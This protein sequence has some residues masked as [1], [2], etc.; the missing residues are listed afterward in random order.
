[1]TAAPRTQAGHTAPVR[2]SARAYTAKL[3]PVGSVVGVLV[4]WTLLAAALAGRELVPYPW[5]VLAQMAKDFP[6]LA[7]GNTASTVSIAARGFLVGAVAMIPLAVIAVL[8]PVTEALIVQIALVIHSVPF[9]AIAP[10][11]VIVLP[12]DGPKIAIAAL[13][14]YFPLLMSA[15]LGLRAADPLM[16]D[17]VDASGGS[18]W[19]LMRRVRLP[20]ALPALFAGLQIAV[21]GALLGALIAEFFGTNSGL[22]ALLVQSQSALNTERAWAVALYISALAALGYGIVALTAR[23]LMPWQSK[24]ASVSVALGGVEPSGGPWSKVMGTLLSVALLLAG[25]QSLLSALRLDAFFVKGPADV[26]RFLIDNPSATEGAMPSLTG[27]VGG[28]GF[29]AEFWPGLGQTVVDA[30]AGFLAGTVGAV[31]VAV[32]LSAAPGLE[33]VLMPLAIALKSV[34]LVAMTPLLVLVLGRNLVAVTVMVAIITFFPTL[35]NVLVAL[36]GAPVGACDVVRAAGGTAVQVGRY[37]RL[38]YAVPALLAS[39]RIAVPAAVSGAT[40]AEWLATD[41][42]LGHV[43]TD[44]A[45][46]SDFDTLWSAGFLLVIV[47]L[48]LYALVALVDRRVSARLGIAAR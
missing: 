36:K 25:W 46:G 40:L 35:V 28:G 32:L 38:V 18:R 41:Q 27:N 1:M 15:L 24:D 21:P 7:G 30:G 45:Q 4:A 16:A 20:A 31:A 2:P 8:A 44:A 33:R 12:G 13:Q 47:V 48:A 11:L 9:T 10:I 5:Q 26:L 23:R 37:I 19:S 17:V 29:W 6:L 3:A 34:P 43:L 39:A 14:V 22:G 42:G